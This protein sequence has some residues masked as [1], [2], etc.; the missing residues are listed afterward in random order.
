MTAMLSSVRARLLALVLVAAVPIAVIAGSNAVAHYQH[1]LDQ[2]TAL[3]TTR[4]ETDAARYA[5]ALDDLRRVVTRLGGITDL[6]RLGLEECT[7]T[8][9]RVRAMFEDRYSN[10]WLLD[11]QGK[12]IC[13]CQGTPPGTVMDGAPAFRRSVAAQDYALGDFTQGAPTQRLMLPAAAPVRAE[14]QVVG[15]VGGAILVDWFRE[16]ARRRPEE[17]GHV[18]WLLDDAG[19]LSS[20][21]GQPPEAQ[22]AA[23]L[24]D[25]LRASPLAATRIGLSAQGADYAYSISAPDRGARVVVGMPASETRREAQR[26]LLARFIDLALFTAACLFIILYGA[27]VSCTRPLRRLA[28]QVRAWTPGT[29][30]AAPRSQWDPDEVISL[31]RAVTG[32]AETISRREAE[33]THALHQR[34][35]LLAE[36]HHRVKNNL[37]IVASLLNMQGERIEDPRLRAEFETARERVQALS[38]LHRHLYMQGDIAAVA[39][40]PL[41]HELA[42]QFAAPAEADI[43]ADPVVLPAEQATSFALLVAEVLA[44]AVKHAFRDGRSGH[45]AIALRER[46]GMATLE[47]SDDGVGLP[48]EGVPGGGE[49]CGMGLTLIRGF[50]AHLGGEVELSGEAGTRLRLSFPT[51]VR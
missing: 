8:L 4:R 27:E 36:I 39:L 44:N 30:F 42:A 40:V 12:L 24:I 35:L 19:T 28:G 29:A 33:L 5:V 46:D 9:R 51:Q 3:A 22:P 48:P 23:A 45:V 38:T 34:D 6:T 14:G 25:E 37:Q 41:L 7:S 31:G 11:V 50:A 10:L 17:P 43:V 26:I 32:A 47:I 13:D 16:A 15:I 1:G 2:L 49:G 21:D 20:L 18:T